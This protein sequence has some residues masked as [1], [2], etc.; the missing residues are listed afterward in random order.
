MDDARKSEHSLDPVFEYDGA[1]V[2]ATWHPIH[3]MRFGAKD[4]PAWKQ[5]LAAFKQRL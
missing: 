1:V 4:V 5:D 2:L 3:V